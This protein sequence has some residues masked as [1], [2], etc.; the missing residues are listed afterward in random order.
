MEPERASLMYS[1]VDT[2]QTIRGS[3]EFDMNH[4][5]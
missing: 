5:V 4:S 1:Q 2:S 3:Y